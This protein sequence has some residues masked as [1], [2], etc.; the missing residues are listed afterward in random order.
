MR[1][2]TRHRFACGLRRAVGVFALAAGFAAPAP[3][4]GADPETLREA[5]GRSLTLLETS[6]RI[7][8]GERPNCFTCHHSGLPAA[9]FLAAGEKGF[10]QFGEAL[11]AQMRFTAGVLA[12]NRERYAEGRGPGGASFG[13]AS[14]LWALQ[15][16]GWPADETTRT[17]AGYVLEHQ[18]D[19][20][21]WTPPSTR[22]PAEESP[23]SATYVA[24][25]SLRAYG[26]DLDPQRLADR[27]E[28]ARRWL[29]RT[30]PETTED[31]VFRLLAL[32]SGGSDAGGDED[33]AAAAQLLA[34]QRED[35]GWGQLEELSSDAYATATA[36]VGLFWADPQAKSD[37]AWQRGLAWLLDAQ[38]PDGSW[39]VR[40]RA[41]P[42]QKYYESGYPH[43]PDQFLSI[44]AACWAT[45]ALLA[46]LP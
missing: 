25:E 8:I 6:S 4:S 22:P 44:T 36:L 46:A 23:F 5:A 2:R 34:T 33:T 40:S 12:K 10:D 24:L 9:A 35:G 30:P 20:D 29:G 16:G 13:A 27:V 26:G 43:G 11:K 38:L 28:R 3:A 42:F 19:R 14:A 1:T 32:A 17:V 7:A 18:S 45:I 31:R 15:L 21:F 39:H 37:P 41:D